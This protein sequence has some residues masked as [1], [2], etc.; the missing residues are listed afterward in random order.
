[1]ENMTAIT[2]MVKIHWMN[3]QLKKFENAEFYGAHK[4]KDTRTFGKKRNNAWREV[5]VN[6]RNLEGMCCR[7]FSHFM[8]SVYPK[9]KTA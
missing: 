3:L 1:M 4:L 2:M 8:N 5:S 6:L 9:H 7:V